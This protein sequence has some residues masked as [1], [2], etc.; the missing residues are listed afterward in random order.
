VASMDFQSI[1]S[2]FLNL[3]LLAGVAFYGGLVLRRYLTDGARLFPRVDR[4]DPAH[5][6]ERLAVWLGVKAL[7]FAVR[8]GTPIFDMLS[9]ASA[10][11]GE[12][13]LSYRRHETQ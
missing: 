10:E 2:A 3:T 6:A 7:A 9:E 13:F 4:R 8:I 12:W 1:F 5:S 11:V